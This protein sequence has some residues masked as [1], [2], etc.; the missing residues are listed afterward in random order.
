MIHILATNITSPLG[1][2]T[3]HNYLAVRDGMSMLSK[4]SSPL[5]FSFC[6]SLF[7][8]EQW[9]E[10]QKP[11]HTKFESIVLHSVSEALEHTDIDISNPRT[12]LI[13]SAT[14]G[15]D[16]PTAQKIA[17]ALGVT[18]QPI[19]VC[20]ACISGVSAQLLAM[21]MLDADYYDNAIVV[22][23]DIQTPFIISGFHSLRALSD[24]PCLPFDEERTGLNLGEG[25]ATIIFGKGAKPETWALVDGCVRNDAFHISGPHPQGEGCMRALQYITKDI[26]TDDIA[27]LSMHGTATM[28]NDQMESKAIERAGLSDIPLSALK[29]YYGHTM[30][31]AGVI[32]T[33]ITACALDEGLIM[34]SRGYHTL[35]VS[36]QVTLSDE[37]LTTSKTSF[38]KALSGFGGCNGALLYSKTPAKATSNATMPHQRLT[39]TL[40]HITITPY[41]A[42]VNGTLLPTSAKGCAMLTE[43]YKKHIDNYPRFYKMDTLSRLAFVAAQ[44][45]LQE[46]NDIETISNHTAVILFNH[47]SSTVADKA[48][49]GTI[50]PD[51]YFPSPAM[52]VYTLPN[53]TAGE[54]ALRNTM[55][56]ETSFYILQEA[57]EELM[58]DIINASTTDSEMRQIIAG[59][60]DCPDDNTFECDIKL[61]TL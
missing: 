31:A 7:S 38:I 34:P 21:R 15:C 37:A 39:T 53:I 32:E 47:S 43:L 27:T 30:G 3:T 55:H 56:G 6:A 14:K 60:I 33:I 41:S 52:F 18:T 58:T 2:T 40:S 51:N 10:L 50:E 46:R 8:E 61:L 36:G 17:M 19:I 9:Q 49:Q 4:H 11:R 25:A 1:Y 23:A 13:I 29:G 24:E 26:N 44:L 28:Y 22:G 5:P 59:W 54:I 12:L 20:N 35:G 57:D 42:S 45:L 16:A 48:F